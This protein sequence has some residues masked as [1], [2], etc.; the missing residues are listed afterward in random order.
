[1][2]EDDKNIL[3]QVENFTY[4]FIKQTSAKD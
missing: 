2:L 1:M 3:L 4:C